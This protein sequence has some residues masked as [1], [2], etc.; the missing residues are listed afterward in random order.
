MLI[1]T[2]VKVRNCGEIK[3]KT[4]TITSRCQGFFSQAQCILAHSISHY[5]TGHLIDE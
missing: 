3:V 4:M 1:T 5:L 2:V